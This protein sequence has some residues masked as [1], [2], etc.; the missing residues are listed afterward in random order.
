[1]SAVN[2]VKKEPATGIVAVKTGH[3]D[4][5]KSWMVVIT[6]DGTTHFVED[7]DVAG[8]DDMTVPEP[9]GVPE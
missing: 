5:L 3:S 9:V 7:A 6:A 2:D 4:P 8:W 1:M